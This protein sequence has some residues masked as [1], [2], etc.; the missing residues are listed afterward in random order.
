MAFSNLG[1]WLHIIQALEGLA[2]HFVEELIE[3]ACAIAR[4]RPDKELQASDVSLAA[5]TSMRVNVQVYKVVD[6]TSVAQPASGKSRYLLKIT[7]RRR[8]FASLPS[9][10]MSMSGGVSI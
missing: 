6:F 5:G 9:C 10:S 3:Q 1:G 8:Q 2:D 4:L 7:G